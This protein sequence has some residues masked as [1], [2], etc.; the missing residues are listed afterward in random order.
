MIIEPTK[1]SKAQ[2]AQIL[3]KISPIMPKGYFSVFSSFAILS[4]VLTV[5]PV[6]LQSPVNRV[7]AIAG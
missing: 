3:P 2:K 5:W 4:E 7:E 6:S 1:T